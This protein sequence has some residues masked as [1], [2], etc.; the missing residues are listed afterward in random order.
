[1]N[2]DSTDTTHWVYQQPDCRICGD[3]RVVLGPCPDGP[4]WIG[5]MQASC[6]VAHWVPCPACGRKVGE[7]PA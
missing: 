3:K 6:C 7:E 2:A 4:R 5:G 1:M